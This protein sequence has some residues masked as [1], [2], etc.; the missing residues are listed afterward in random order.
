MLGSKENQEKKQRKKISDSMDGYLNFI[1]DALDGTWKK[2]L[3]LK[4]CEFWLNVLKAFFKKIY[5]EN[6]NCE[7][8]Y[9][10]SCLDKC[11][12]EKQYLGIHCKDTIQNYLKIISVSPGSPAENSSLRCGDNIIS[13][14]NK[15]IF[16]SSSF[17]NLVKNLEID[18]VIFIK[19]LRNNCEMIL[20]LRVGSIIS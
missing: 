15:R 18:D 2:K 7:K 13:I 16:N 10:Q 5:T 9:R 8:V 1:E 11:R 6:T 19:V 12:V 20:P 14:N 4:E 3:K 17:I